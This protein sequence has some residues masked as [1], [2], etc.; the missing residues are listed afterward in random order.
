MSS[1]ESSPLSSP[2][3]TDDEIV[4][5]LS[6][7]DRTKQGGV[8]TPATT[9][10]SSPAQKKRPRQVEPPHEYVLA[11]NPDIAVSLTYC[12]HVYTFPFLLRYACFLSN[13][14]RHSL[15]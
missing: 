8:C 7:N 10:G 9:T 14:D 12:Y 13:A 4:L 2:P 15:L 1:S 11:D 6:K 5:S 3:S